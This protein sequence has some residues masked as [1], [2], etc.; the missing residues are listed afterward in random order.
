[1]II[2]LPKKALKYL[3][4]KIVQVEIDDNLL[5]RESNYEIVQKAKGLLKKYNI[6][7]LEYQKQTRNEWERKVAL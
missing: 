5:K 1:M 2:T 4:S 7:G 3:D 6:D